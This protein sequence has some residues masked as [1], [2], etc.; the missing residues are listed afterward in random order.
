MA[1][2]AIHP[3]SLLAGSCEEHHVNPVYSFDLKVSRSIEY[4][5]IGR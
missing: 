5:T 1:L 3:E 4:Y 2:L